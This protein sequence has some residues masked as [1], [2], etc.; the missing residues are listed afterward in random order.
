MVPGTW[1]LHP[2]AKEA[3]VWMFVYP[4]A[5][6]LVGEY[7]KQYGPEEGKVR[8]I[9]YLGP[10]ADWEEYEKRLRDNGCSVHVWG[11]EEVGG[12]AWEVVG[13]ADC[14]SGR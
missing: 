10:R 2:L 5:V 4:R 6:G 8:K 3:E 11:A 1:A 14:K 7:L 12:R 9:V 13:V